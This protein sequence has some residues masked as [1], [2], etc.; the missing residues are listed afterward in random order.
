MEG[1]QIKGSQ[2]NEIGFS[3]LVNGTL[4]MEWND[5]VKPLASPMPTMWPWKFNTDV[6]FL[7]YMWE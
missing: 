4:P 5:G 7:I 1:Q 2:N 3:Q 6:K